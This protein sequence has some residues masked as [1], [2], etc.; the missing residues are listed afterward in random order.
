[1]RLAGMSKQQSSHLSC[2]QLLF[3]ASVEAVMQHDY[4]MEHGQRQLI[5]L[6]KWHGLPLWDATWES[7][8][9][10]V[11]TDSACASL[12]QK[13]KQVYVPVFGVDT[14]LD[15]FSSDDES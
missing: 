11:D 5:F 6:V 2:S 9:Q 1:M 12:L 15:T 3:R 10:L 8:A 14:H 13:Y 4:V 7:E